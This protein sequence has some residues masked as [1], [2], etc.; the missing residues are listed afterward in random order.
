LN[1]QVRLTATEAAAL[2]RE[3]PLVSLDPIR[4]TFTCPGGPGRLDIIS[5]PYADRPA[6]SLWYDE[7][8]CPRLDNGHIVAHGA[9][10]PSFYNHFAKRVQA[11]LR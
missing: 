9:G 8:G 5:F 11:L 1:R 7:A 10:N 2:T 3:L 6:V 4:A